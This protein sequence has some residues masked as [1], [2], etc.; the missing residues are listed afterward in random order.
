ML[1]NLM[2]GT[3]H[4]TLGTDY[5]K[6]QKVLSFCLECDQIIQ[7]RSVK[8]KCGIKKNEK[9]QIKMTGCRE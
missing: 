8:T 6:G 3:R 5:R 1:R 9:V 7:E 2:K 4:V